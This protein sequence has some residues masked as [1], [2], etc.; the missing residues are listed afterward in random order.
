MAFHRYAAVPFP[1]MQQRHR[2]QGRGFHPGNSSDAVEK[3]PVKMHHARSVVSIERRRQLER[4]QVIDIAKSRIGRFQIQQAPHEQARS[5]QQEETQCHLRTHQA[6]A[7]KQ[8]PAPSRDRSHGVLQGAPEIR[9]ACAQCGYD[10]EDQAGKERQSER[11][12][13]NPQ[14]GFRVDQQWISL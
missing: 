11:E 4:H 6:F 5:E 9:T 14:I 3:L 2:G 1:A 10:P 13:E 12:Q 7:H 8:G